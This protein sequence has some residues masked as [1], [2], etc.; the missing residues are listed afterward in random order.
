M[1]DEKDKINYIDKITKYLSALLLLAYI[2]GFIAWNY[3][4]SNYGFF[5]YNLLQVR[6]LSA[7]FLPALFVLIIIFLITVLIKRF[8]KVIFCSFV[9]VFLPL[10][11]FVYVRNVF[12]NWPPYLG[13]AKP[14]VVSII[15]NPEQIK[16]LENFN[17][18]ST[19]NAS[20][21]DSV[22]T[23]KVCNLYQNN[24]FVVIG[25]ADKDILCKAEKTNEIINFAKPKRVIILN[26]NNISGFSIVPVSNR[27][28]NI[29]CDGFLPK[30][31]NQFV[32]DIDS[33]K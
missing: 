3:H 12:S 18:E 15:A 20:D 5:E 31:F 26:R 32:V 9:V 28:K 24:E 29:A 33:K 2:F 13:G 30:N 1:K 17:I 11:Y 4:L 8:K 19:R 6:Y 7:G 23:I 16:M 25:V 14:F 10:Y 22:E 27:F 21:K